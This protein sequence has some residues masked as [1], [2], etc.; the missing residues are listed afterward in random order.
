MQHVY[1]CCQCIISSNVSL[2]VCRV[3]AGRNDRAIADSLELVVQ[4]LEGKHNQQGVDDE[5]CGLDKFQR[6]KLPTFKD[7]YDTEGA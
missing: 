6:N 5:L 4:A 2:V 1:A 3:M 7:K